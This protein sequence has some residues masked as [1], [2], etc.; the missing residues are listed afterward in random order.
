[1]M[2]MINICR[3]ASYIP[4]KSG[5]KNHLLGCSVV[6]LAAWRTTTWEKDTDID[7]AQDAIDEYK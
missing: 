4:S 6:Q 2:Q 3:E 1:M 5:C 7:F